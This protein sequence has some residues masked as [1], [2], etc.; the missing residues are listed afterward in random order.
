MMD[1]LAISMEQTIPEGLLTSR[2]LNELLVAL[3]VKYCLNDE[4]EIV[5]SYY[6]RNVKKYLPLL[7]IRRDRNNNTMQCGENPY[8][9]ASLVDE[10]GK[11]ITAPRLN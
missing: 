5:R 11:S 8:F 7:E 3:T 4:E 10:N 1:G 6:R 2:K 9:V